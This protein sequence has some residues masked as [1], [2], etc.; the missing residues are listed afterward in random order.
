MSFPTL[1]K[2]FLIVLLLGPAAR[3]ALAR[4][5][6]EGNRQVITARDIRQAGLTRLSD[7]FL[8]TP[9]WRTSTA[10]GYIWHTSPNGLS[11]FQR[12]DWSVMLDG[13]RMDI[14]AFG[15]RNI[16]LVPVSLSEVDSVVFLSSPQLHEGEFN[17]RGLIHIFTRKP[18]GGV[19][20]KGGAW[21][22]NESGD[23]G[24]YVFT[25]YATPNVDRL[26]PDFFHRVS[27][28]AGD[29]YLWFNY[30]AQNQYNTDPAV[31]LRNPQAD[32]TQ[33]WT[34]ARVFNARAGFHF[35]EGY[36]QL[37]FG[38]YST[39][40]SPFGELLGAS[41]VYF[42]VA[43]REL[44]LENTFWHLGLRG[45]ITLS[46]TSFLVYR[47]KQSTRQLFDIKTLA[48][49]RDPQWDQ[50]RFYASL[51]SRFSGRRTGGSLGANWE[52]FTLH[53][54]RFPVKG[55]AFSL[56]R[57]YGHYRF[58]FW[59]SLRHEV[60]F[61]VANRTARR[62]VKGV[63]TT[64]WRPARNSRVSLVLSRSERLFEEDNSLFFWSAR[65]YRFWE[66]EG[67]GWSVAGGFTAA[68]Q[69]TADLMWT[70][71]PTE[72]LQWRIAA[73]GR[74]F[75][76]LYLEDKSVLYDPAS[77]LLS[78]S[79]R[80]VNGIRGSTFTVGGNVNYRPGPAWEV[81]GQYHWVGG[82]GDDLFERAWLAVPAN[83]LSV[84]AHYQPNV[85]FGG[86]VALTWLSGSEWRDFA[87]VENESEGL[88]SP[89]IDPALLGDLSVWKGLWEER[90]TVNLTL[91]NIL[92]RGWRSQPVGPSPDLRLYLQVQ[93]RLSAPGEEKG[94]K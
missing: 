9:N 79:L 93:L 53:E 18:Q 13:V 41:P 91:R 57:I 83:R 20:W 38:R 86:R 10:D 16:N 39:E 21:Y 81:R 71:A 28:N 42:D 61:Q 36:H 19:V 24:P 37:F 30:L 66:E 6:F 45:E 34:Q 49:N 27:F 48:G 33:L 47:V 74:R 94:R 70:A 40:D 14:E 7:I 68:N 59:R 8:L 31:M 80:V 69:S 1:L 67:V 23:P 88:Y 78:G 5:G 32:N 54:S 52:R 35:G 55:N 17:D 51:E 92:N 56:N 90:L 60:A 75:S 76:N 11:P 64:N 62:A 43:N 3:D 77:H 44:P 87:G 29:N 2:I 25:E 73:G 50:D 65:D 84:Q 4:G 89:L 58:R 46:E 63:I 82:D 12:Q 85:P 72:K 26:G 15:V 22:G